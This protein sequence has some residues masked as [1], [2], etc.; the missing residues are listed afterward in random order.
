[1]NVRQLMQKEPPCVQV[2]DGPDAALRKLAEGSVAVVLT[3]HD[4]A[5][6]DVF[7]QQGAARQAARLAL[8]QPAS[9]L[10]A[11]STPGVPVLQPD[12][13]IDKAILLMLRYRFDHLPVVRGRQLV[14]LLSREHILA[15]QRRG[16]PDV[17]TAANPL[18]DRSC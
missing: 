16:P 18:G 3:N 11:A 17:P 15:A 10:A 1:M 5:P 13:S 12:D 2:R 9:N 6:L 8:A 7:T 14:G 4:G